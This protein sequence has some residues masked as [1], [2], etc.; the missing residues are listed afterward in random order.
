MDV[1]VGFLEKIRFP[2]DDSEEQTEIDE[3]Q[4]ADR[5]V[6]DTRA[7]P[8][9]KRRHSSP[10]IFG[11]KRLGGRRHAVSDFKSYCNY[12]M[13]NKCRNRWS[14][15][16]YYD[17]VE[18]NVSDTEEEEYTGKSDRDK[19]SVYELLSKEVQT[20]KRS[21][22]LS[23]RRS[24]KT[25][26]R[27]SS[28]KFYRKKYSQGES[29][30]WRR[31]HTICGLASPERGLESGEDADSA[32]RARTERSIFYI[33]RNKFASFFRR[34]V[35]VSENVAK[36]IAERRRSMHC[37][38]RDETREYFKDKYNLRNIRRQSSP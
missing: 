19:S 12:K 7:P 34:E 23:W 33:M 27:R 32:R 16:D 4:T 11:E 8:E 18:R 10:A 36:K 17:I 3:V 15:S 37:L 2:K 21:A 29:I 22:T 38:S 1:L 35:S 13:K 5:M 6:S 9:S 31:R 24:M 25:K 14:E 26:K 28:V 20:W 30:S